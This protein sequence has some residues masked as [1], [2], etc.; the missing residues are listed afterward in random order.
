MRIK[1]AYRH[2]AVLAMR[3]SITTDLDVVNLTA[4]ELLRLHGLAR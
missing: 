3:E 4:G 1:A 2:L